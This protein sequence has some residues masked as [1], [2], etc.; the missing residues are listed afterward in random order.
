MVSRPSEHWM[1]LNRVPPDWR[2]H[3][4]NFISFLNL[5]AL[6]AH[7]NILRNRTDS[8]LDPTK[9]ECGKDHIVFEVVFP[10]GEFWIA[11]LAVSPSWSGHRI[12]I[13]QMSSEIA[14]MKMVRENS[15]IPVPEVYG[16]D[17][18]FGNQVGAPYMFLEALSG[19]MIR[20]LRCVDEEVK[21]HV[22]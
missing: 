19:D 13:E 6:C 3:I 11:R 22:F 9:F 12:G 18:D 15:R 10:H 4:T 7:A 20:I 1:G 5:Q 2:P 8:T 17:L 21:E 14:T 16:F